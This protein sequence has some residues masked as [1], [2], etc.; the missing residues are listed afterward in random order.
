LNEF[1][2]HHQQIVASA[3]QDNSASTEET[4]AS[5]GMCQC[6]CTCGAGRWPLGPTMVRTSNH[7][8]GSS[9]SSTPMTRGMFISSTPGGDSEESGG[10]QDFRSEKD[11]KNPGSSS[12]SLSV[13][14]H[15]DE[16]IST[17]PAP[18]RS[19]IKSISVDV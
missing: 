13:E 7:L 17:I 8:P 16:Q 9:D 2:P 6:R 14:L 1:L 12:S 18:S 3:R 10:Q 15:R 5:S 4:S 19:H 11:H